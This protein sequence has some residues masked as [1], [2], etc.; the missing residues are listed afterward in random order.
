[1]VTENYYNNYEEVEGILFPKSINLIT[2]SIPIPGGLNLK[3][4]SIMLNVEISD[5]DFE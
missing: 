3:A 4:T 5:S 2:P 1:M